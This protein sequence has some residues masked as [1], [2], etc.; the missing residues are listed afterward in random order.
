MRDADGTIWYRDR[1]GRPKVGYRNGERSVRVSYVDEAPPY[2]REDD[3]ALGAEAAMV[4][5]VHELKGLVA[6][7]VHRISRQEVTR[8]RREG[9]TG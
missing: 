3:A 5:S 2:L 4:T 1:F 8:A 6:E 9:R 7:L